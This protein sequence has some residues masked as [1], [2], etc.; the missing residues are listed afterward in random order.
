MDPVFYFSFFVG[1]LVLF[2]IVTILH[3]EATRP[4]PRCGADIPLTARRCKYCE[5]LFS[6]A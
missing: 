2:V 3:K 1:A 6:R 4:C 5:Y